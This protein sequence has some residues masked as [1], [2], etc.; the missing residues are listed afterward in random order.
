MAQADLNGLEEL[1]LSGQFRQAP[2]VIFVGGVASAIDIGGRTVIISGP[3]ISSLPLD[4]N[5]QPPSA[6]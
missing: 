6:L 3:A 5:N 1:S 2:F 4:W